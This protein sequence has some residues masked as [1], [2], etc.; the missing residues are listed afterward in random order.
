MWIILVL[1][2]LFIPDIMVGSI[3]Q[4]LHHML[5]VVHFILEK[6]L[7]HVLLIEDKKHLQLIS[8]YVILVVGAYLLYVLYK[9][10][11]SYCYQMYK[12]YCDEPSYHKV[13]LFI[14]GVL[15]IFFYVLT[16]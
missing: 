13:K 4:T 2:M 14:S 8:F 12:L 5:D 11:K 1:L 6:V 15:V 10:V 3:L 9:K 7:E 16:L